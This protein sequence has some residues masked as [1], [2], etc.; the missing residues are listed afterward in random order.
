MRSLESSRGKLAF[1]IFANLL[2]AGVFAYLARVR[3]MFWIMPA[4]MAIIILWLVS[5][6]G[7]RVVYDS[8]MLHF[9]PDMLGRQQSVKFDDVTSVHYLS[10]FW[11]PIPVFRITTGKGHMD[12]LAGIMH[13]SQLKGFLQELKSNSDVSYDE[14]VS[15][16]INPAAA[17][18]Y[19]F[20]KL[21][22]N[23]REMLL[24]AASGIILT[25]ALLAGLI[26]Y[27]FAVL[28]ASPVLFKTDEARA[29][30]AWWA[31]II[32]FGLLLLYLAWRNFEMI[33]VILKRFR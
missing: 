6:A 33:S 5:K 4:F 8:K 11:P 1:Y 9:R 30:F 24:E 16:V 32:P 19:F 13:D 23:L 14:T 25:L 12:L 27:L 17:K 18:K 29:A 20:Q 28:I 7:Q 2:I 22:S 15:L 3:T 21:L 31:I 26:V 10:A